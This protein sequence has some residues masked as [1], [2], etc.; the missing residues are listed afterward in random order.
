[1]VNLRKSIN[2]IT[3]PLVTPLEGSN[4]VDLY[5]LETLVEHIISGGIKN[6][7]ILGTTGEGPS[8]SYKQRTELIHQ[9][10]GFVKE[11]GFVF[12]GITD[13]SFTESIKSGKKA[14]QAGAHC[15][16]A[17]PP[18][19][20][21]ASQDELVDYFEALAEELPLP[22]FLYNTPS[23][24]R[25]FIEVETVERLSRN[26]KILGIK[27]SSGD[28]VFVH[29]LLKNFRG[30]SDFKILVGPEELLA[31]SVEAGVDGG[32][33]GGAN[34]FPDLY[35]KLYESVRTGDFEK[36]KKL[37]KLV[38][39]ISVAVYDVCKGDLGYIKGLKCALSIMGICKCN[40]AVP[41]HNASQIERE[42]I[43][44]NLVKIGLIDSVTKKHSTKPID[45]VSIT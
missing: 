14:Y 29:K 33:N 16:V 37:H 18:Y 1:M 22:L 26:P 19:Y 2:G 5:G 8:L 45:V 42:I 10:C 9:T 32:V 4:K 31:E 36:S 34:L 40:V 43:R 17:A 41:Y 6:L 39:D 11:K 3:V 30:N 12:V 35:V 21:S 20:F 44:K 13:T 7:F 23:Q 27:D 25:T 28:M 15:L 38:M 24:T